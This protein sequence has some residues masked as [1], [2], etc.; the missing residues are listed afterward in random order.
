MRCL[1]LQLWLRSTLEPQRRE[2]GFIVKSGIRFGD[3][4][5][6]LL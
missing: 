2:V 3:L 5:L 1:P 4:R 6:R